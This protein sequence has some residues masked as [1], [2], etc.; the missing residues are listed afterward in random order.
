MCPSSPEYFLSV[1]L[2]LKKLDTPAIGYKEYRLR[3][4]EGNKSIDIYIDISQLVS[5]TINALFDTTIIFL[6]RLVHFDCI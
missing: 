1:A 6:G 4:F 2:S 5:P 3:Q